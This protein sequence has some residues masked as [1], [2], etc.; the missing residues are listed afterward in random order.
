MYSKEQ[1]IN[2]TR[3]YVEDYFRGKKF[4]TQTDVFRLKKKMLF[5]FFGI[6]I[7]IVTSP[8]Q[9]DKTN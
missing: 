8:T 9:W 1:I 6:E 5:Y 4:S 2:G 3:E 7:Q